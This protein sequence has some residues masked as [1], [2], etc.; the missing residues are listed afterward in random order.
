MCTPVDFCVVLSAER[1]Q[2]VPVCKHRWI[3][4]SIW[5][6]MDLVVNKLARIN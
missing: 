3:M 4:Q 5:R 2:V 1:L 6:Y